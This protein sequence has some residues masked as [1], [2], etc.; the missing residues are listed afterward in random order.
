METL[1][2]MLDQKDEIIIHMIFIF[3]VLFGTSWLLKPY[4]GITDIDAIA[5]IEGTQSIRAGNGFVYLAGQQI[6]SWPV[7]YSLILALFPDVILASQIINYAAFGLTCSLI[8][9]LF[10]KSGWDFWSTLGLV[11]ALGFGFLRI[12][13]TNAKPD[14]L[15]Y[16]IFFIGVILYVH[17]DRYS[18]LAY[19]FWNLL[20]P[21]K[22]IALVFTPA[23]L[24][25]SIILE[26]R[27]KWF[28]AAIALFTWILCLG[29]HIAFNYWRLGSATPAKTMNV[30]IYLQEIGDFS[31]STGRT[32]LASWYGSLNSSSLILVLFVISLV[33]AIL[34]Y[35]TLRPQKQW[36]ANQPALLGLIIFAL[37]WLLLTI[38]SFDAGPRLH[39]YAML[40]ILTFFIPVK[41]LGR[42]WLV[43]GT[44]ILLLAVL[45]VRLHDASGLNHPNYR[46][47][48]SD[49]ER[50]LTGYENVKIYTNTF[51]MLP[52]LAG[53]PASQVIATTELE[54]LN[55]EKG[56]DLYVLITLP[57]Y[58]AI[59]TPILE[60]DP[61]A[62]LDVG[63]C[64][65][66]NEDFFQIY[67][68]C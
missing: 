57:N 5:Y 13:S 31:K 51:H 37:I 55:L 32:F 58:D 7:G 65:T 11:M 41:R 12:I 38:R 30:S 60:V 2:Q 35:A 63:W 23:G 9:Y 8:Y 52:V 59:M 67:A 62:L 48:T 36:Q 16:A 34:S 15:T 25:L 56:R 64:L 46:A 21:L 19:I 54:S 28:S 26:R 27:I 53:I 4:I 50:E 33:L 18:F 68:V 3:I 66:I 1:Q 42:I 45:N 14:I 49:I 44:M 22:Y 6:G 29:S 20:I 10:R 61:N 40:L 47:V 17:S 43:Y 24:L 39:G